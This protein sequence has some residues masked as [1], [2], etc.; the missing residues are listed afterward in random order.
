MK[1]EKIKIYDNI[2]D[3][4]IRLF[5]LCE[6]VRNFE[7]YL[8]MKEENMTI[9]A[10]VEMELLFIRFIADIGNLREQLLENACEYLNTHYRSKSVFTINDFYNY[11]G[12]FIADEMSSDTPAS[13]YLKDTNRIFAEVLANQ[14]LK[15]IYHVFGETMGNRYL[16]QKKRISEE[17]IDQRKIRR[18]NVFQNRIDATLEASD[19]NQLSVDADGEN[20]NIAINTLLS[21]Q[22]ESLLHINQYDAILC[23]E[24]FNKGLQE[25][26]IEKALEAIGLHASY[27]EI[28]GRYSISFHE[29]MD[30][31]EYYCNESQFT[32]IYPTMHQK[33]KSKF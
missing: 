13:S 15:D 12:D 8:A 11:V 3:E 33:L 31:I 25:N 17:E 2:K 1:E 9:Y 28:S 30:L 29:K 32:R 27:D 23:W 21:A 26:D 7:K 19:S 10:P 14:Y 24:Q 6:S 22:L 16:N 20:F 18:Y 5:A 4:M